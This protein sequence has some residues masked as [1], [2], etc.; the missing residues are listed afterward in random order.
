[1]SLLKSHLLNDHGPPCLK[2]KPSHLLSL[3]PGILDFFILF[4]LTYYT[5]Y[6]FVMFIVY[7]LSSPTRVYAP[8][9]WNL[10]LFSDL[11]PEPRRVSEKSRQPVNIF[12][13]INESKLSLRRETDKVIGRNTIN[14][15]DD[16]V[17]LKA[18]IEISLPC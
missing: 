2:L 11:L 16:V 3:N 9:E 12:C 1:M 10:F 18:R 6:L 5:I 15:C 7:C 14:K 13:L 8:V 17:I 4:F